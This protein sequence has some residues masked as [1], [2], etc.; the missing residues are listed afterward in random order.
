MVRPSDAL[1]LPEAARI[2]GL[3]PVTLRVQIFKGRL[4]AVKR[5]RDWYVTRKELERYMADVAREQP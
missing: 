2:A 1:T 3:S 4:Q 5:G